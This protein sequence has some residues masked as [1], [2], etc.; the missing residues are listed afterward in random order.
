[1]F[2]AL[3]FFIALARAE[4]TCDRLP[5]PDPIVFSRPGDLNLGYVAQITL[6][7]DCDLLSWN[8]QYADLMAFT[9]AQINRND[10]ILPNVTLGFTVLD[11]CMGWEINL[12]RVWTLL[13]DGCSTP[14]TDLHAPGQEAKEAPGK[15]KLVGMVGPV[16]SA[17]SVRVSGALAIHGIPHMGIQA[18]SDELSDKYRYSF[19]DHLNL[20]VQHNLTCYNPLS[21]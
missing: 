8:H 11:G 3:V 4:E 10:D 9:V 13:L 21:P 1:M 5:I 12:A 15:G 6:G 20:I 2:L 7:D 18:T 19:D 16:Y 14:L 17:F